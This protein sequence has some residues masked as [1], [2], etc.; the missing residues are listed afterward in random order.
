M[1]IPM[2]SQ[3]TCPSCR[4]TCPLLGFHQRSKNHRAPVSPGRGCFGAQDVGDT[5]TCSEEDLPPCSLAE[6]KVERSAQWDFQGLGWSD[7][8]FLAA[9]YLNPYKW[10]LHIF[11]MVFK[12]GVFSGSLGPLMPKFE[13]LKDQEVLLYSQSKPQLLYLKPFYSFILLF[14]KYSSAYNGQSIGLTHFSCR[15]I[16]RHG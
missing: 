9:G 5:T 6:L 1:L 11:W 14:I 3:D 4:G 8:C 16:G 10:A 13:C 15:G 7:F 12:G 2:P